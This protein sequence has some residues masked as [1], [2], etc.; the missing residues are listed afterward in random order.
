[1]ALNL[2]DQVVCRWMIAY[3][4]TNLLLSRSC[5]MSSFLKFDQWVLKYREWRLVFSRYRPE[6]ACLFWQVTNATILEVDMST[7]V[8]RSVFVSCNLGNFSPLQRVQ[9]EKSW[10]S[11]SSCLSPLM[12]FFVPLVIPISYHKSTI[13]D[14]GALS[15]SKHLSHV[16]QLSWCADFSNL[17]VR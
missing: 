12:F 15:A 7:F 3:L 16:M 8:Q 6:W 9:F 1:V 5:I 4:C 13:G 17:C 2:Q 11:C 14:I 10:L